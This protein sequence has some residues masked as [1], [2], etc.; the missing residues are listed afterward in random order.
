[1]CEKSK[2]SHQFATTQSENLETAP[3]YIC[4][5]IAIA[6]DPLISLTDTSARF[7]EIGFTWKSDSLCCLGFIGVKN[8]I[9]S[10]GK[11]EGKKKLEM[12]T[13]VQQSTPMIHGNLFSGSPSSSEEERH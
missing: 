4:L 9:E 13:M 2:G 10:E 12:T 11:S 6:T 8:R 7:E 3:T 1:M 5:A